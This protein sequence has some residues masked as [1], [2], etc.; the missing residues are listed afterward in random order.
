MNYF[1][2]IASI[3]FYI[4]YTLPNYGQYIAISENY[5]INQLVENILINSPCANVSN[6]SVS[7]INTS[8]PES[9]GYFTSGTS[10]FPFADGIVLSTGKAVSAIGPNTSILSDDASGW[11]GDVDLQNA[12]GL[13]GTFNATVLEFDFLPL[14]DKISFEYIFA[15]E[16]YLSNPSQ[17]QCGFTD[18]F[19]FLLKE[20]N[21]SNPYQNLAI[22]PGTTLPVTVSSIRGSG[23]ICPVQNEQ[24][25]DAF[26]GTQHPT[27]FN[28]QTKTLIAKSD[29]IAGNLYHIKLVIADQGNEKYDSAIFLKG[30]SFNIGTNLGVD[31]LVSNQNPLCQGEV[32]TLNATQSSAVSYKWFKNGNPILDLVSGLPITSPTY[33]VTDSGTY[34][35]EVVINTLCTS[36]DEIVI[37]YTTSPAVTDTILLQ[38]DDNQDGITTYDLTKVKNIVTGN[39][40]QLLVVNYFTSLLEAQN[41][42]NQIVYPREFTNTSANQ[43]IHVRI[44]NQFNCIAFAKITLQITSTTINPIIADFC[45]R[46]G[47]QDGTTELSQ[48]DFGTISARLLTNLPTGLVV[49]Y[50]TTYQNAL[51]QTD[52]ISLSFINPTP[53]QQIV[54]AAVA[55]GSDCYGIVPV[56]LNINI[57]EPLGFETE[58]ISICS[59]VPKPISV[60]PGYSNYVWTPTNTSTGNQIAVSTSGIYTVEVTN[61]KG[62]KATK[63]FRV[64]ASESAIIQ[65]ITIDDFNGN[66]NTLLINYSGSGDYEF[67]LDGINFQ[68]S[69]FFSDIPSGEYTIIVKDKKGCGITPVDIYVLAYP[70]FF[71]PNGDGYNDI[72][73]IQNIETKPNSSIEL[74]NR[75]GKLIGVFDTDTGWNGKFNQQELPSDDY[76]FILKLENHKQIKGHFALKR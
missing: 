21:T 5:T 55:N 1:R 12:L 47:I 13:S 11:T 51:L 33:Q 14:T 16:Q 72:W 67:S 34:K 7:G 59:G 35:V 48:V 68:D 6:I 19:V 56:T 41:N 52:A 40:S 69:N 4:G 61:S 30:G 27:N 18:G 36:E 10:G 32:F 24:F 75:Y 50:H 29:V 43:I 73:K 70:T 62:C 64:E 42:T 65:N 31:K 37:E 15:S 17:N 25:F 28:G 53:F 54:Y 20:A 22:V 2:I 58:T 57:F 76:W 39:D 8:G 46:S 45:D 26:N 66:S 3:A 44:K 23:T 9:Y 60:A 74:F 49:T 71:T 38:C 63:E